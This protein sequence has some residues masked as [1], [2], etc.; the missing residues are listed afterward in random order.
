M[1][2]NVAVSPL[3]YFLPPLMAM[4]HQCP[5]ISS[6]PP[7]KNRRSSP[8]SLPTRARPHLSPTL[9]LTV[10]R[11]IRPVVRGASLELVPRRRRAQTPSKP[12]R[13]RR[14]KPSP[15]HALEPVHR[16]PFTQ[17]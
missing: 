8:L 3:H 5:L 10:D 7:Y 6:L 15:S 1:E 12:R 16:H 17:G 2:F 11:T 14:A 9:L 13:S 4:K